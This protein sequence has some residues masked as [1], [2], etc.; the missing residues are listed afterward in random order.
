VK[1]YL[2]TGKDGGFLPLLFTALQEAACLF[3]RIEVSSYGCA[4][5]KKK[6]NFSGGKSQQEIRSREKPVNARKDSPAKSIFRNAIT[7][8]K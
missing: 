5:Q 2:P 7:P 8:L 3:Y 1:A 6:K 4:C